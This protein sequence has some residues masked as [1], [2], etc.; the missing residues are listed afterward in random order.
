[1]S[2]QSS[3]ASS[4]IRLATNARSGSIEL[5]P[6]YGSARRVSAISVEPRIIILLG[7][8]PQ[9]GHS[10]PTSSRS[11]PTTDR[12]RPR[13]A[14]RRPPRHPG[15]SRSPRRRRQSSPWVHPAR[16]VACGCDEP[17]DRPTSQLW[18]VRHG[19][20][21][22]SANGRHTSHTDL[23]LTE[24][25]V[26][27]ARSVAEKLAGT[28]F[29]RV[30][31]SPLLR[32]RRTAELAGYGSAEVAGRPARVGLR[33]RRGAHHAADP[34]VAPRLDGVA[35]RPGRRRVG[36]DVGSPGRPGDRAGA[37]GD[38]R[39]GAGVLARALLPG[40]RRPLAAAS[41][42]ATARTWRCRPRRCRCSAG[43]ATPRPCC[44]GTTPARC[45]EKRLC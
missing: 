32:A 15:P 31:T 41:R 33:R 8:Q 28:S 18:L 14:G 7:T 2:S 5:R 19:E 13:P 20:T 6:A 12:A 37:L 43:S 21:E 34:G 30:L 1:M 29:A 39:P 26:E 40:A 3:V 23:D 22:W 9:Y 35:G 4:R 42:S 16:W 36:A 45:A 11:T 38:R 27:A 10:P 25:G 24:A 44:T 17:R